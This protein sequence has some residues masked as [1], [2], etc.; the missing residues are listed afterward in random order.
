MKK[1]ERLEVTI[2]KVEAGQGKAEAELKRL[3]RLEEGVGRVEV[4]AR[5]VRKNLARAEAGLG[6]VKTLQDST[7]RVAKS[8]EALA[9][10]LA[11]AEK[12]VEQ[13]GE[14]VK[15]VGQVAQAAKEAASQVVGQAG[16]GAK[17]VAVLRGEVEEAVRKLEADCRLGRQARDGLDLLDLEVKQ[18]VKTAHG[19]RTTTEELGKRLVGK[20]ITCM[21][22]QS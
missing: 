6:A 10:R 2:G 14:Q 18:A 3:D 22:Q 16:G 17:E 15:G 13:V 19:A 20:Y 5:E 12:Q 8:S 1:V 4:E 21:E 11:T 7:D 9:Q